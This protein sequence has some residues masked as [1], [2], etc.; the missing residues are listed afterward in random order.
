LLMALCRNGQVVLNHR[1]RHDVK[2]ASHIGVFDVSTPKPPRGCLE[3][4]SMT[5]ICHTVP[6]DQKLYALQEQVLAAL[7]GLNDKQFEGAKLCGGTALS[8]CWLDHRVSYDLDFFLPEGFRALALSGA[9]KK[10]GIEFEVVDV[11]DDTEKDNQLHGYV[12]HM[13]DRLK[14][15]FIEDSYFTLYPAIQKK[16]GSLTVTTESI[17]GLYHRKLRTVS[18]QASE[19]TEVEG[20]RQT[21]R[22]LFDLYVL[23]KDHKPIREFITTLTYAFP[24]DAFDNGLILMAWLDLADE[25][26]QIRCNPKWEEAKNLSALREALY[27]E[28]GAT[29]V[30]EFDV[31][32]EGDGDDDKPDAKGSDIGPGGRR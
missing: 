29:T 13:G 30:D 22:D 6:M 26:Q 28:I 17:D 19:G 3:F 7:H 1:H 31:D 14:V 9:L 11:V 4:D 12:V 18:G 24:S 15:S 2:N 25:L 20:G 27:R 23:S 8:R 16:F 21:A 10:G 5:Y 32:G